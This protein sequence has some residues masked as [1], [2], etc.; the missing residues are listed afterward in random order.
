MGRWETKLAGI[1]D[2]NSEKLG[3][4]N[5]NKWQQKML[6]TLQV[7]L[8]NPSLPCGASALAYLNGAEVNI[9][10]RL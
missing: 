6:V 9:E 8:A 1:P 7:D 3:N 4:E 10:A 2:T 5:D